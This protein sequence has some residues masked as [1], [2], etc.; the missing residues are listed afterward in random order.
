M[1]TLPILLL[2]PLLLFL[3]GCAPAIHV[4]T[5]A[6][7]DFQLSQYK[8]FAFFEVDASGDGLGPVYQP[9]VQRL[10]EAVAQQLEA[11][12][13]TRAATSPDLL[14][15]LGVVVQEQVQTRQTSILTDPPQYIGQRRYTWR[16]REVEVGRY[17]EGSVSVHLVNSA[18]NELVWQGTAEAI[19]ERKPV[20]LKEQLQRGMAKLF[21]ELPQ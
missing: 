2:M 20:K 21:R 6:A 15:N 18:R 1:K 12:G 17:K 16:S 8:T 4:D 13:M 7:P 3:A 5:E 11:R 14:V 19:L 10:Q 9:Q